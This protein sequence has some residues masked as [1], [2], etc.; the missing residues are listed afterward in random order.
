MIKNLFKIHI[1]LIKY[2]YAEIK[3]KKSFKEFCSFTKITIKSYI[4]I[5]REEFKKMFM[6]FSPEYRKQR[7][8]YNK[9]IQVQKDLRN[10]YKLLKYLDHRLEKKGYNKQQKKQFWLNFY[11]SGEIRK[12]VWNE[13][14]KDINEWRK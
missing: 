10:A 3:K 12:D 13:L 5:I 8:S 2:I 9:Q 7:K 1:N 11:K 14:N 6:F 4:L